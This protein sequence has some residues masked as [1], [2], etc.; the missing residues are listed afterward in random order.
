MKLHLI[1]AAMGILSILLLLI[2]CNPAP[3][4]VPTPNTTEAPTSVPDVTEA[5]IER[6]AGIINAAL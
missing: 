1:L 2:A 4:S 6:I 5:D 3:P